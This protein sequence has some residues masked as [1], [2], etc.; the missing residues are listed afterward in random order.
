MRVFLEPG[1]QRELIEKFKEMSGF[2]F[3][4]MAKIFQVDW[5][6]FRLWKCERCSLP[7]RVFD[8]FLSNK[9]ILVDYKQFVVAIKDENWSRR[10]MA[11][12][13]WLAAKRKLETDTN[14][15]LEWIKRCKKGGNNATKCGTIPR[16][17]VG[18]RNMFRKYIGPKGER[19]LSKHEVNIANLFVENK[20]K[21]VYEEEININ[22]HVYF[23]D[24][25]VDRDIIEFCGMNTPKYTKSMTQKFD[26][27]RSWKGKVI[28]IFPHKLKK[29][30]EVVPKHKKFVQ[31]EEERL[32]DLVNIIGRG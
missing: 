9:S 32:K 30:M 26:D 21:Y 13:G 8:Y 18:F 10:E 31:L 3:R 14:F 23:P 5:K 15:R 20:I 1:K 19:M 28:I 4:K 27:F 29:I 17:K 11:F 6:T 12:R 24:F 7:L 25:I 22:K 2:S 16:W